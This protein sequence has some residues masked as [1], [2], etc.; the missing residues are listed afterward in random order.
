M[1]LIRFNYKVYF[2]TP[3]YININL[4]QLWARWKHLDWDGLGMLWEEKKALRLVI[5]KSIEGKR[6]SGR[7]KRDDEI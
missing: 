2:M 7:P 5:E 1:L 6:E 4:K 3:S